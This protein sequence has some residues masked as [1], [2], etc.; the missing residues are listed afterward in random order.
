[1]PSPEKNPGKPQVVRVTPRLKTPLRSSW[2]EIFGKKRPQAGNRG[3]AAC[4]GPFLADITD[5]L[6]Q[7]VPLENAQRLDGHA[8]PHGLG[9]HGP[10]NRPSAPSPKIPCERPC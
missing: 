5:R 2:G 3:E 4:L 6:T 8:G 9:I 7:S 1:M 10:V